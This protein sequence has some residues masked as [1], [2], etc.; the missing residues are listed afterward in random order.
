MASGSLQVPL[1]RQQDV[2]ADARRMKRSVG[3]MHM[4]YNMPEDLPDLISEEIKVLERIQ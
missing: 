1:R 4:P 3:G 2:V